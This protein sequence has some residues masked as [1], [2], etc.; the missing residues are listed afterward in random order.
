MSIT[1]KKFEELYGQL[2]PEQKEAVD[3]IE[4][5][6]MVVAGPGTGKTQ[7]L[8]L[9][10]A[11]ILL[12]TQINPGNILALTFSESGAST[13]RR[14][15][16]EI[17]GPTAYQVT[18][19]TFH[20]FCNSLLQSYPEDFPEVI[21]RQPTNEIKQIE[22]IQK[23]LDTTHLEFLKPFGE[24][25][26]YLPEIR[27]SISSLKKEGVSP[28][29]FQRIVEKE[30]EFFG[31][32]DDLYYE[33]G[34]YKG[35]MKG[36]YIDME[37]RLNK[38]SELAS[39]YYKYQEA[40]AEAK[41]YDYDDMILQTAQVL[42]KD[43][44]LLIRLQEKFQYF[45]VDEH[46]DTNNAQNKVLELLS[47]FHNQ[48]NL[49]VVGDEKQAIFRF[50]GA[51]LDNFLFFKKLYPEAKLISLNKN[52]R[53]AQPILDL[54]HNL[55]IN[56]SIHL[57][58]EVPEIKEEL[59]SQALHPKQLVETYE[60]KR[61]ETET[62]FV[63]EKIKDLI[64]RGVVAK[65]VA[66]IYRDNKD[67]FALADVLSKYNSPFRIESS[68]NALSDYDIRKLLDIFEFLNDFSNEEKL[69]SIIH[70]DWLG[71][72]G[73]DL[74]KIVSPGVRRKI[75]LLEMMADEKRLKDLK[76]SSG[77]KLAGISAKLLDWHK[78]SQNV[79]L[80]E[81]FETVVRDSGFLAHIM[82]GPDSVLKLNRLNAV[83]GELKKML[84]SHPEA[85][86]ADFVNY[87]KTLEKY[88][89]VVKEGGL[90]YTPDAVRLMTAHGAKG[91][92]FDYVFVVN[93]FDGHWGNRR[94]PELIKLNLA[95]VA[96]LASPCRS[97][98]LLRRSP[99]ISL[100][101]CS[102]KTCIN[103][104]IGTANL[105]LTATQKQHPP[106]SKSNQLKIDDERRLFYVALTR[107]R[108]MAYIS[109]SLQSYD[110]RERTPSQFITEVKP[111]LKKTG[112]S[113]IYE[114]IFDRRKD[115]LYQPKTD[116][117]FSIF[118]KEYLQSL[119]YKRGLS[120]TALNNYL[121]C[122]WKFF[123]LNLLR[124]P[125]AKSR[126]QIYGSAIHAGLKNFFDGVNRGE[127]SKEILF[128]GFKNLL[129]KESLSENDLQNFLA[130]G[131]SSLKKYFD[132][133]NGSWHSKTQNEFR[134]HDVFI[135]GDIKLT[136]S[137]DKIEY[138]SG[139]SDVNVVDYKTGKTIS[140]NELES[141]TKNATGDYK[142]QLVFYK[143][144]L[145]QHPSLRVNMVSGE[146]DFIEPDSRGVFHKEK[147]LIDKN[148][149]EE[150]KEKVLEISDK[151]LNFGFQKERCGDRDCEYCQ[152]RFNLV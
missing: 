119:F 104:G 107:A 19:S 23:I 42:A 50:Q 143:L 134:V 51:S 99:K 113:E 121:T 124:I 111:E 152:L 108:K 16:A 41:L 68:N 63:A 37:R 136:G 79:S 81:L 149:V 24:P 77:V 39:I 57:S 145:D 46:Q 34:K 28:E 5:P 120:A 118:E 10:I 80:A 78:K 142:R 25:Y 90:G 148:E 67:V 84:D 4:G 73:L 138:L 58:D 55:I 69:F 100:G 95:D 144:L 83:F 91:L 35:K 3:H 128:A 147:F 109:Y 123:Y 139:G 27:R 64:G 101:A 126:H 22:F 88:K 26:F 135:G 89:V 92:E 70:A 97:C 93:A 48:P 87:L 43:Q 66:V 49:F 82:S 14:R 32:I 60:F 20:G 6:V 94:I 33:S 117:G 65:E 72:P 114:Q 54:A 132:Y 56:N 59:I 75:S 85:K 146:I 98:L 125:R 52:Y 29:D 12:K 17:I 13:M 36:K 15:L 105:G 9:R 112:D 131:E 44:N 30:K 102:Q 122:P 127:A 8:T 40:L 7:V 1:S 141:K 96:S 45:L 47:N 115:L 11:N 62:I 129:E 74:Y 21:G 18:I 140:R 53:S 116:K 71:I 103:F 61:P 137:L 151:V 150:L 106:D 31:K 133:Y 86:L 76:V 110:G 2:N 38:N 130:K